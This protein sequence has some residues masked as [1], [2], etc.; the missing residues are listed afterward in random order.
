M[1][2]DL[3]AGCQAVGGGIENLRI[4]DSNA[5]LSKL[6]FPAFSFGQPPGRS[7]PFYFSSA[8]N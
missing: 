6:F 5:S 2:F 8:V 1:F 7:K 3:V 4:F